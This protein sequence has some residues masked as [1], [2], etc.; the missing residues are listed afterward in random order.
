ML[1]G[2]S[3]GGL[4]AA[5]PPAAGGGGG[6][7]TVVGITEG[8]GSGGSTTTGSVTRS[9]TA[10]RSLLICIRWYA[11]VTVSSITCSGETVTLVGSAAANGTANQAARTQ[12]AII[13]NIASTASKTINVTYSGTATHST[14]SCI[15]FAG[16]LTSGVVGA[17]PAVQTGTATANPSGSITTTAAGSVI[18]GML[19][20]S[21]GA[22]TV[23]AGYTTMGFVTFWS[24]ESGQYLTS[25]NSGAAGA[26]TVGWTNASSD[27]H[28]DLIEVLSS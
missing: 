3:L 9:C 23:G 16:A 7:I 13:N 25:L 11:A 21:G 27:W 8:S 26:K 2:M 6:N 28:M 14:V 19:M 1:F 22:A 17:H 12:F 10:G 5:R 4:G 18:V 24:Y 20:S 15:E